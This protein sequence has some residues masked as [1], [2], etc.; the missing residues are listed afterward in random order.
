[1]ARVTYCMDYRD[2]GSCFQNDEELG[3]KWFSHFSKLLSP[4]TTLGDKPD[5]EGIHPDFTGCSFNVKPFELLETA[6]K[7][8]SCDIKPVG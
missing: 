2:G 8:L 4:D 1:M 7:S 6:V 5:L 3:S